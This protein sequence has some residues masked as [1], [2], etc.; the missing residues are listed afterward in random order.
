MKHMSL[1]A[2]P[3]TVVSAG[4]G[5]YRHVGLLTEV[6]PGYPQRVISLNPGLH[7]YQVI[8]EDLAQFA[9]GQDVTVVP[10]LGG[11]PGEEVLRRARSGL[12]QPYAWTL[13][14][15]EHFVRFAHALPLESPQLKAWA[16]LGSF[17][18]L[19][20]VGSRATA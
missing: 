13:F 15:C 4:R 3:G 14:N 18:A 20:F 12:H 17:A 6:I 9:R 2:P 1:P 5:F 10:L 11:L 19:L 8:E 16:L 7:G